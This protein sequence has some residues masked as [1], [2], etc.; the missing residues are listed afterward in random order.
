MINLKFP[1][2]PLIADLSLFANGIV[3]NNYGGQTESAFY[4]HPIGTGPFMWAY[5][6][7]GSGPQ[8]GPQPALLAARASPT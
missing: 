4:Q 6:H 2:A 5:W 7:K 1:W 3:P 8:A